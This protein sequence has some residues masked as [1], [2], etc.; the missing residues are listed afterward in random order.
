LLGV[1]RLSLE[2]EP[3]QEFDL[4]VLDAFNSDAIPIHLLTREAFE[5]YERH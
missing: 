1:A 3:L 2:R 5:L 4:L